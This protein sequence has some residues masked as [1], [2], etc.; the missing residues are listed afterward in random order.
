MRLAE[1]VVTWLRGHLGGAVERDDLE[2]TYGFEHFLNRERVLAK[3]SIVTV[4]PDECALWH[5]DFFDDT[6][7]RI[8]E[9]PLARKVYTGKPLY[10]RDA[11]GA[12]ALNATFFLRPD[13]RGKKFGRAVYG[14]ERELY[15][16]WGIEEI[17]IRAVQDGPAVWVKKFG[18]LPAEPEVLAQQYLEWAARAGEPLEPPD[19]PANYPRPFLSRL[20]GLMLYKVLR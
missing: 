17:H 20:A 3:Q 2:R 19:D 8:L 12:V 6:S 14:S 5:I 1:H 15:A 7:E 4:G 9:T 11:T 16:R 10:G 13:C 18:F